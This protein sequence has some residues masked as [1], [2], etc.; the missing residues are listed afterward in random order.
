MLSTWELLI[1][2][3]PVEPLTVDVPEPFSAL[4]VGRAHPPD[5]RSDSDVVVFRDRVVG[6]GMREQITVTNYGTEAVAVT[7]EFRGDVDFA[8]LFEVKESRVVARSARSWTP[9]AD[10][11]RFAVHDGRV[12]KAVTLRGADVPTV[13]DRSLRWSVVLGPRKTWSGC[14]ECVA[15]LG[16]EDL[17]PCFRCNGADTDSV[18]AERLAEWRAALP[19]CTPITPG[20]RRRCTRPATTSVRCASSTPSIPTCRSS[21][22]G[23]P[24]FMTVFGRDS[25]L[26]AWMALLAEPA[27]AEGVLETL[28]RFQGVATSTRH[29]GAA[30]ARSCTRCASAPRRALAAGFG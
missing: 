21:R 2:G 16:D 27:L 6:Q 8:D 30:R 20:S 3:H 26:T 1:D 12:D 18:P 7:V 14:V 13:I 10:G 29:R 17:V 23:L 5:G 11:L 25:L 22:R 15:A 28:A 9:V 19:R 4:F 24:W